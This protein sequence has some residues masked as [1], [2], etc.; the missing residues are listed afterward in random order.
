MARRPAK[1]SN[2]PERKPGSRKADLPR[3]QVIRDLDR[4][5]QDGI[6]A[7]D[8]STLGVGTGSPASNR[9]WMWPASACLAIPIAL[10][11]GCLPPPRIPAGR[12]TTRGNDRQRFDE[13]ARYRLP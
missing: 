8:R 12:G 5:H 13:Q 7:V 6:M 10:R 11:E 9:C 1:R 4:G 3:R 2:R